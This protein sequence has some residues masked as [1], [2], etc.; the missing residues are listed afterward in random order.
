MHGYHS[1][2]VASGALTHYNYVPWWYMYCDNYFV[3]IGYHC[4]HTI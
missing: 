3:A 2:H 1:L 4:D